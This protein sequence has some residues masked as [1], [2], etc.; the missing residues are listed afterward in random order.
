MGRMI[1][2]PKIDFT[3][4]DLTKPGEQKKLLEQL[5]GFYSTQQ[6][7]N[8][9]QKG[10]NAEQMF[11]NAPG[12]DIRRAGPQPGPAPWTGAQLPP[13]LPGGPPVTP[14]N[15]AQRAIIRGRQDPWQGVSAGNLPPQAYVGPGAVQIG[16]ADRSGWGGS[17]SQLG[18][19]R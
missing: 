6:G 5:Q 11:M 3:K 15:E 19:G 9:D 10:L 2:T 7:L 17:S 16:G 4:F 18:Y 1:E 8:L 14:L 13:G 12:A